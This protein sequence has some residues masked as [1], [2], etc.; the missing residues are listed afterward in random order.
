LRTALPPSGGIRTV[1]PAAARNVPLVAARSTPTVASGHVTTAPFLPIA[2]G[3][4]AALLIVLTAGQLVFPSKTFISQQGTLD[5]PMALDGSSE[6]AQTVADTSASGES[7]VAMRIPSEP[8]TGVSDGEGARSDADR[9]E[10]DRRQNETPISVDDLFA[11]ETTEAGSASPN[12]APASSHLPANGDAAGEPRSSSGE[13]IVE[14]LN[15]TLKL[16]VYKH[17][18]IGSPEAP[19]VMIEMVSYDCPHCR[20]MHRMIE[21][22]LARYRSQMAIIVMPIPLESRCNRLVTDPKASHPGACSTAR[23]ALGI[24]AIQPQSFKRFHDWLMA[25]KEK[26]PREGKVFAKAY[27]MV[28]RARLRPLSNGPELTGQIKQYVELYARLAN[29]ARGSKNFGLPVQI[30]GNHI[31]AGKAERES[32]L[33]EAWE[34]HLGVTGR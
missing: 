33:F 15:G 31:M 17:A 16:D 32:D 22:G 20:Q 10:A 25:D 23:M 8:V 30:L 34:K 27:T 5:Q 19:H 9:D 1:S 29:Q 3:G 14:F 24:A 13:R 12:E 18:V 21:R 2:C 6:R 4:A 11:E 26:P 28:D 7:H